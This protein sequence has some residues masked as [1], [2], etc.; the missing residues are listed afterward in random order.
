MTQSEQGIAGMDQRRSRCGLEEW[1]PLWTRVREERRQLEKKPWFL[2]KV[3]R[4][5]GGGPVSQ[6]GRAG[7]GE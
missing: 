4:W 5:L 7:S 2:T 3:T 6:E 1:L